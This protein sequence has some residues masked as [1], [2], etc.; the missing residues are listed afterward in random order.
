MRIRRRRRRR[1]RNE[2]E[3]ESPYFTNTRCNSLPY[4]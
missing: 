2:E 4:N 1:R 3:E